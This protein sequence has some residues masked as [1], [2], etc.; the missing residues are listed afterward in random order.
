LRILRWSG[1]AVT[2]TRV[3]RSKYPGKSSQPDA[4]GLTGKDLTE[5]NFL[6]TETDAAATSGRDGFIVEGCSRTE[7][8]PFDSE[9]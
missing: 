5:I 9:N 2:V 4:L 1:K 3:S 7:V 6:A 8:R